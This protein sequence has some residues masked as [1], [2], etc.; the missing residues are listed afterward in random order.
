MTTL[1][2]WPAVLCLLVFS[3]LALAADHGVILLYHH[4]NTD[5]PTSTSISP[6]DFKAHLQLIDERGYRVKPLSQLL[7]ELDNGGTADK[8]VAITFDDA[9]ISVYQTAF[10]LLKK[11]GWP[12]TV[13]VNAQ[14]VDEQQTLQM[15]WD[16]LRELA[17]YGAEIGNHS[18]T[19]AHLVRY[20]QNETHSEWLA[21]M[22]HEI[23][24][25]ERRLNCEIPQRSQGEQRL[26]AY[27]FGEY[28]PELLGLLKQK[29]YYSIVQQSGAVAS[30][31]QDVIPRFPLAGNWARRE[32]LN[33][34]LQSQPL[35]VIRVDAGDMI[36]TP[37]QAASVL[38]LTTAPGFN[39]ASIGCYNASGTKL[40]VNISGKNQIEV[41]LPRWTPGRQKVNCTAPVGN[42]PGAY[43]WYS[44]LWIIEEKDAANPR[45]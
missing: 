38:T 13:F 30:P 45:S 16:Q 10:P 41:T 9:Y 42:E 2:N 8:A 33:T 29:G 23:V 31:T 17:D 12:F 44:Q 28:N 5:T 32:R 36:A 26:F 20:L 7:T 14:S 43:Y 34:A 27:P 15:N 21:R 1:K 37:E 4:V 35:P 40:A 39:L 18:L 19:H 22:D 6:T 24:E 3:K 11:R 25:N